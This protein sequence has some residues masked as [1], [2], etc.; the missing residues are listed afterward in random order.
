MS[1]KNDTKKVYFYLKVDYTY[2]YGTY[3]N[4]SFSAATNEYFIIDLIN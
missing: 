3:N 1:V 4:E 2:V